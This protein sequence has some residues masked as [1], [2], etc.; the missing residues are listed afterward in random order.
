MG[1]NDTSLRHV[2]ASGI[3]MRRSPE[4]L[5]RQSHDRSCTGVQER[6]M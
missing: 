1:D 2:E 6:G 3:P 5:R 4:L